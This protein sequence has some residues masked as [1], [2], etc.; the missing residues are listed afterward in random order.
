MKKISDREGGFLTRERLEN[1]HYGQDRKERL[2]KSG[3]IDLRD[4]CRIVDLG[5][6][7][8]EITPIDPSKKIK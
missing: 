7:Y 3:A 2:I 6:G 4:N 5:N 8:V 1:P